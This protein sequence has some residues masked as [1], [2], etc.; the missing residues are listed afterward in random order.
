MIK[1][2]SFKKLSNNLFN[3]SQFLFSN[4]NYSIV[5]NNQNI[6]VN[7]INNIKENGRIG[8]FIPR[9]NLSK[10]ICNSLKLMYNESGNL[11]KKL[12]YLGG[13]SMMNYDEDLLFFSFNFYNKSDK[14][15]IDLIDEII[16]SISKRK[17]K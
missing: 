9:R 10:N 1:Y 16:N 5:R 8:I 13:N 14:E 6:I 11:Y 15:T 4:L 17:R 12:Q 7:E 3:F 2:S